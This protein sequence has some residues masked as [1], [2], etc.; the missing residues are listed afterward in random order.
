MRSSHRHSFV[1]QLLGWCLAVGLV[2]STTTAFADGFVQFE[3]ISGESTDKD[4]KNWIDITSFEQG[5]SSPS[6]SSSRT[7]RSRAAAQ[8][9][10]IKITKGLDAASPKLAEA[11]AQGKAF[12]RVKLQLTASLGGTR[13][14]YYEVE[15]KNVRITSY[16]VGGSA[17]GAPTEELSLNFEEIKVTYTKH[18]ANGKKAGSV[19]YTWK[20]RSA[21]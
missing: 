16:Q 5:A 7:G 21:S 19:S 10:D 1:L 8:F 3:G 18:D 9:S 13:T 4:H 15:L 14:T 11:L 17:D 6:S 12:S 20:L 2:L